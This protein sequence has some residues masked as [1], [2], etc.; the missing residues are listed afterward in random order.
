[1]GGHADGN[2]DGQ[3]TCD[4]L[5]AELQRIGE[6]VSRKSSTS[7]CAFHRAGGSNFAYIYH[8]KTKPRLDVYFPSTAADRFDSEPPVSP[9][10]RKTLT[11]R[12]A[13][14]F[15][16]HFYLERVVGAPAAAEF[17]LALRNGSARVPPRVLSAEEV[18]EGTVHLEGAVS[19][20][21]VNRYERDPR[22]R[23]TCLRIL[24]TRCA[25]CDFD[26]G[27]S[28]GITFTG[29]IT[30]HHVVP[31]S[32]LKREYVVDPGVDLVP[33]CGNCHL[34]V[35]QRIPPFSIEELRGFLLSKPSDATAG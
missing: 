16:W 19:T 35:H 8:A 24:G 26:F 14:R 33:L 9:I 31:L 10:L 18:S 12:W 21:L 3:A 1:M 6:N 5:L 13:Q 27:E 29:L 15:A 22:A 28:Y 2:R 4:A 30:V 11:S 20:I 25:A 17:L 32:Q 7:M 23:A 34:I